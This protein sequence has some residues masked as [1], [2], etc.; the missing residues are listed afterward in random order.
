MSILQAIVCR[1]GSR[2][3]SFLMG[4]CVWAV[5]KVASGQI[6]E[7]PVLEVPVVEAVL[8]D[9]TVR[10]AQPGG[11]EDRTGGLGAPALEPR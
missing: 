9:E 4:F 5:L 7:E 10:P 11:D 3:A 2:S 6:A 8:V 1:S